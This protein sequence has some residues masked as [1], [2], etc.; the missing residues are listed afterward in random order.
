MKPAKLPT[1]DELKQKWQ[2]AVEI[3]DSENEGA[4]EDAASEK[5][6]GG[7]AQRVSRVSTSG[8][9]V[10]EQSDKKK[11]GIGRAPSVQKSG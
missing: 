4:E 11:K 3:S 9:S 5:A 8:V 1:L 7:Q 2:S 10:F 6:E